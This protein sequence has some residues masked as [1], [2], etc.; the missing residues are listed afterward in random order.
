M[1]LIMVRSWPSSCLPLSQSAPP[2]RPAMLFGMNQ[3]TNGSP[4][5]RQ[6]LKSLN[7]PRLGFLL[8]CRSVFFFFCFSSCVQTCALVAFRNVVIM[9]SV[10]VFLQRAAKRSRRERGERVASAAREVG[11]ALTSPGQVANCF[12]GAGTPSPR[13]PSF[14]TYSFHPLTEPSAQGPALAPLH[15]RHPSVCKGGGGQEVRSC[16]SK[17]ESRINSAVINKRLMWTMK[18]LRGP[19]VSAKE[20]SVTRRRRRGRPPPSSDRCRASERSS[21]RAQLG[22]RQARIK[23]IMAEAAW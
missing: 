22:G 15:A 13:L 9:T 21:S 20:L 7:I 18:H 4:E 1:S 5:S 14:S 17:D 2:P 23:W 19:R 16:M 8:S 12:H 11:A 6:H 3:P 10:C